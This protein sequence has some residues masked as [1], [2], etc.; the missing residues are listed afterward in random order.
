[1][2]I[3]SKNIFPTSTVTLVWTLWRSQ[4]NIQNQCSRFSGLQHEKRLSPAESQWNGALETA[5]LM[6]QYCLRPFKSPCSVTQPRELL[7]RYRAG[8]LRHS[9]IQRGSWEWQET[10]THR[11]TWNILTSSVSLSYRVELSSLHSGPDTGRRITLT[12]VTATFWDLFRV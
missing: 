5:E 4:D 7:W 11:R 10:L 8:A 9:P 2:L 6:A 12:E 1:M 3:L